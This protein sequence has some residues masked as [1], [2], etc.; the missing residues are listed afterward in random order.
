MSWQKNEDIWVSCGC[1]LKVKTSAEGDFNSQMERKTHSVDTSQPLSIATPIITQ[2][3]HVFMM[4]R[5]EVI[6]GL[7]NMKFIFQAWP[8]QS[9]WWFLNLSPLNSRYD[10]IPQ[11]NQ[12]AKLVACW[13]CWTTF[14][15][16]GAVFFSLLEYKLRLDSDLPSLHA[17]IIIPY[18]SSW[19]STQQCF[20]SRNSLYSKRNVA[21]AVVK[22]FT[23]FTLLKHMAWLNGGIF[24]FLDTQVWCQLGGN[25][26]KCW[27][28][29]L[30]KTVYALKHLPNIWL[31]FSHR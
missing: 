13:L 23:S 12:W 31:F 17:M 24:F 15:M 2:W 25:S 30:Q 3:V 18:P 26:F 29:V 16:E 6:D 9:H 22:K 21:M 27:G 11:D 19:C 7:S 5:V 28:K 1:S 20:W 4:A 14:I 10:T 8:G